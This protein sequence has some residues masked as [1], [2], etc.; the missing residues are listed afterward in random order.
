MR[1][2]SFTRRLLAALAV[3]ALPAAAVADDTSPDQLVDALNKVFGA[4]KGQRAAHTKG[5][6]VKGTFTPTAEAPNYTKAPHFAAP[7]PVVARFSLGGGNP[8][9]ADNGK[10]AVRGIAL[11][12]DL[13]K[14]NDTDLLMISAPV[15]VAKIPEQFL[16]LL[17]TVATKDGDKIKAYLRANPNSTTPG[18]LARPRAPCRRATPP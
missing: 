7:V 5:I 9:E 13:G 10:G 2:T 1:M 6:C 4:H 12:F 8:E 14:G 16:T 18:C 17:T 3:V 15:F 11:H